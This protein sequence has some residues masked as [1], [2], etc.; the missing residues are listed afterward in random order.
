MTIPRESS[1][2]DLIDIL[3]DPEK[4]KEYVSPM[5]PPGD[6]ERLEPDLDVP[7]PSLSP[8]PDPEKNQRLDADNVFD[9]DPEKAIEMPDDNQTPQGFEAALHQHAYPGYKWPA[10]C[11]AVYIVTFMYGLDVTIVA[12]IQSPIVEHFGSVE[13]LGWLSTGFPL[14]AIAL[15]LPIGKTYGL[16]NVKWTYIASVITFIAGSALCGGAPSMN[17]LIWGRVWQGGGGTGMYLGYELLL[18][19]RFDEETDLLVV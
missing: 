16:F 11:I 9:L 2:M 17:S 8:S 15:I 6:R 3:G 5:P 4:E 14:G 1:K 12:N 10:V 7:S 13:K 18:H 19:L